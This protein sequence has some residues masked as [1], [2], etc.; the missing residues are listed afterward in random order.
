MGIGEFARRSGLSAK[1]LRLYDELGLLAPARVDPDN[2]YRWYS[3]H[4]LAAARLVGSLR[5]LGMPLAQIR[6]VVAAGPTAAA[7]LVRAWWSAAE[8]EHSARRQLAAYLVDQLTGR[9]PVMFEV[10]VRYL[11]ERSLL[12][13]HRT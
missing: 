7:G 11:P 6:E 10:S 9:N 12:C 13:L 4:Q 5:Q 8:C 2:G 3:P 1:A